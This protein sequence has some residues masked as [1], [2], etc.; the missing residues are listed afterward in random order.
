MKLKKIISAALSAVMLIGCVM[1]GSAAA[2]TE[3]EL[4]F[5]DVGPKKWF[6][7][8]V[9]YVW[10][11][12]L[13][14]GVAPDK[15]NPN[16]GMTRAMFV[17]VLGRLAG[18]EGSESNP[19]PDAKNNTWYSKY[20]GWAVDQ[21]IINGYED[22][23]FRP[24]KNLSREEM[25]AC[26]A[27]YIDA[28]GLNMPREN[29]AVYEFTDGGKIAHWASDYV[30][31]LRTAGI[32]RGDNNLNYNPKS[33]IT[34]AEMATLI[35]NLIRA[36][37]KAWQGYLPDP[38][39]DGYAVYGA[40][41]L[42]W[43]GNYVQGGSG[44]DLAEDTGDY[45]SLTAY[46]DKRA[47]QQSYE[48]CDTVG[49]SA[50]AALLDVASSPIVKIC[51]SYRG[52]YETDGLTAYVSNRYA[53][54][55]TYSK[56]E[57]VLTDGGRDDG[58]ET[59]VC[60]LTEI[61]KSFPGANFN[62]NGGENF[63]FMLKPF[64]GDVPDGAEFLIR[65]IA[66]FSDRASADAFESEDLSDY[67]RD[68]YLY[69]NIDYSEVTYDTVEQ[70]HEIIRQRIQEI[71]DSESAVTPEMIKTAGGECYY[72]S[73]IC[74]D[75]SNDGLTPDTPWR[76][77][78]RLWRT[79]AGDQVFISIPKAGDAVFF[80]RGSVFY[81]QRYYNH[82]MSVLDT[83]TDVTYGA[84]GKGDKPVFT[85]SLDFGGGAGEWGETEWDD[86]YVIDMNDYVPDGKEN[87]AREDG[88]IGGII[89][90]EGELMGVRVFPDDAMDPFGEGKTTKYMGWRGNCRDVYVSGGT[91]CLDP[92]DALR[93][94]LEFIH[95]YKD[96]KLYLRCEDGNPGKI[97]DKINVCRQGNIVYADRGTK[98]DNMAFLYSSYIGLDLSDGNIVTNCEAGYC[99]GSSSSVGTGIGGY[100][101]CESLVIDNCYIH[102]IEDGPMGTQYTGE[103]D[104]VELNNVVCTNNV[105]IAGQNLVELFHTN[106]KEGADGLG[107][108]K[109]CHARI[110]DNYAA[111]LGYGYPLSVDNDAS[112]LALHNW[113]YGEM[114][115]CIFER[116]TMVSCQGSIIGA[117]VATDGNDRGW[118]MR[119][120]TYVLD[121][122]IMSMLRGTDGITFTNLKKSFY[123]AYYVPYTERYLAYL[124]SIG[125]DPS[126]TYRV[127]HHTTQNERK[128][129]FVMNGYHFERGYYP[130]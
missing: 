6:Y 19:F 74:G 78:S 44:T 39:A 129:A 55:G 35:G 57:V 86:I 50:T 71:K 23:T 5:T 117:H 58:F 7:E 9:K 14:D 33:N 3:G 4:P 115:D 124:T 47:A 64:L 110:T 123:A 113:Y 104:P 119:N 43:S 20:V 94:N 73:S 82:T 41:Y 84:Y 51:Y 102:D 120:N 18:T 111:Y 26:M 87:F 125:I 69:T 68:Y 62:A 22:G 112:G 29:D 30:D 54:E 66:F 101:K 99:G 88:D 80:E 89:F 49:F 91:S 114:I 28:R 96:G 48:P 36:T 40:K 127:Y 21:G 45:P 130:S 12:G 10:E 105:I 8:A 118:F 106:R 126:G 15:F 72:V 1:A 103:G 46:S 31:V 98:F 122:D 2:A 92:E 38:E 61:A 59:A 37:D 56:A 27:R 52:T 42:F 77:L 116:N 90:N 70:Y 81:G 24:N 93:N 60:D 100:G 108:N 128:G 76:S 32:V 34:R 121:P 53:M 107:I 67:L 97:F 25:A 95:D 83:Y 11:R 75:D 63:H 13:M 65:Y 109:I 17:T 16:G 79:Y 85:M